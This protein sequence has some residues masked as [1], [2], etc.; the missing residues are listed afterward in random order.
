MAANVSLL[1]LWAKGHSQPAC[2]V[3][4]GLVEPAGLWLSKEAA[5]GQGEVALCHLPGL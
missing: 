4:L 5:D 2:A 1:R 3:L